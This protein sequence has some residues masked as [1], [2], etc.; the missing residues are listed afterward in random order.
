MPT[1]F[2]YGKHK[3]AVGSAF[4]LSAA[5]SNV[6]VFQPLGPRLETEP[7][8]LQLRLPEVSFNQA[9][10]L[11]TTSL[12]LPII[13]PEA[14]IKQALRLETQPL[15]LDVAIP[16]IALTQALILVTTSKVINVSYP[17]AALNLQQS[18]IVAPL[19]LSVAFPNSVF[20]S[21][22][23]INTSPILLSLSYPSTGLRSNQRLVTSPLTLGVTLPITSFKQN[24]RIDVSPLSLTLSFPAATLNQGN[25]PQ[26]LSTSPIVLNV[27][28]PSAQ[29]RQPQILETSAINLSVTTP[30]ATLTQDTPG[31]GADSISFNNFALQNNY[32]VDLS[33]ITD[34]DWWLAETDERL[35]GTAITVVSGTSG[36]TTDAPTFRFSDGTTLTGQQELQS[37]YRFADPSPPEVSVQIPAGKSRVIVWVQGGNAADATISAEFRSVSTGIITGWAQERRF[38][39][40]CDADTAATLIIMLTPSTSGNTGIFAVAVTALSA[41]VDAPVPEVLW[42]PYDEIGALEVRDPY[43]GHVG[44]FNGGMSWDVDK[45]RWNGG[46]VQSSTPREWIEGLTALTIACWVNS[47]DFEG[48]STQNGDGCIFTAKNNTSN[49]NNM[50]FMR[51]DYAGF[52][53][54]GSL[55]LK[56]G[57]GR[58]SGTP[59]FSQIETA[60][61]TLELGWQHYAFSWDQT[62][63]KVWKNGVLLAEASHTSYPTG[64]I[65]QGSVIS[66]GNAQ[67]GRQGSAGRFFRGQMYDLRV[68]DRALT[69]AEISEV[70]NNTR[71]AVGV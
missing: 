62:E 5:F 39:F 58:T 18:M 33:R 48:L 1:E 29:L 27:S 53:G 3:R 70:F 19:N 69:D 6:P 7:L 55:V 35:N 16:E 12:A 36:S 40:D 23:I 59:E 31:G 56:V 71:T 46:Y 17:T 38:E 61:N 52:L 68:Y 50:V 60:S 11:E 34:I 66:Q 14:E 41:I 25:P 30:A 44:S 21:T 2:G 10:R 43:N 13:S 67:T 20:N 65:A 57:V 47:D 32:Q 63:M 42:W 22:N 8:V 37:G 28:Q 24:Q 64:A 54:G 51:Q 45:L 15:T 9:L 49:E 4:A 26:T